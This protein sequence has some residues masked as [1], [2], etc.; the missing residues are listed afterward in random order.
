MDEKDRTI[1]V[2]KLHDRVTEPLLYELF[3]QAGPLEKV[4][5]ATDKEGRTKGYAF[6]TFKHECSVPYTIELM[7]GIELFGNNLRLQTRTGS[8]SSVTYDGG[9][10]AQ[11]SSYNSPLPSGNSHDNRSPAGHHQH[12]LQRSATWHGN[13]QPSGRSPDVNFRNLPNMQPQVMTAVSFQQRRERVFQQ[14]NIQLEIHRQQVIQRL[15]A[16]PI[17]QSNPYGRSSRPWQ[18]APYRRY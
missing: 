9:S 4:K 14:Q 11:S 12:N 17:P 16:Q 5:L 10:A 6:V 7:N 8:S 1:W 2:G 15:T 3:L 13:T 18:Q